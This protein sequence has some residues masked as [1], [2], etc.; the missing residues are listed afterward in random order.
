MNGVRYRMPLDTV[1]WRVAQSREKEKITQ[2]STGKLAPSSQQ[3][4]R[5]A[6]VEA[7]ERYLESRKVELAP[8]SV[9][10]ERELLRAP[11]RHFQN[12]PLHRITAEDLRMYREKRA[13]EGK[14]TVYINMEVG[15]IRAF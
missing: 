3:F 6:F 2:A 1:D 15:A 4:A 7:A 14:A 12:T 9:A 10:K 13:I 11:G 8:R 5:L